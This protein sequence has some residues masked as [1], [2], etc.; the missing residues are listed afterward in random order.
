MNE[1]RMMM[2]MMEELLQSIFIGFLW[3][4]KKLFHAI[5]I[6]II[7]IFFTPRKICHGNSWN[8]YSHKIILADILHKNMKIQQFQWIIIHCLALTRSLASTSF[9][10][11]MNRNFVM[12]NFQCVL[13]LLKLVKQFSFFSLVCFSTNFFIKN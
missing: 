7:I 2:L 3:L 8:Y 5:K 12:E 4:E 11:N 1:V 10:F 13:P 6:K 9:S